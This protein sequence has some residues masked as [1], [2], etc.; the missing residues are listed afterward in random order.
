MMFIKIMQ[1][2]LTSFIDFQ[3]DVNTGVVKADFL[4]ELL[5]VFIAAV[6]LV[7]ILGSNVI[8]GSRLKVVQSNLL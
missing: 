3:R 2:L 8:H 1:T 4:F 5:T 7:Y 6:T